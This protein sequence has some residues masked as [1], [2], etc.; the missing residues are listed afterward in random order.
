MKVALIDN[1]NN[2]FFALAR[3]FRDLGVEANLYLIPGRTHKH[4]D[5]QEDTWQD[6]TNADWIRNFPLPYHSSSYIRPIAGTIRRTFSKY[7]K[8]I[9]CGPSLGLFKKAGI[10]VDLFIPYGSDLF[11]L[12]FP[13][14]KSYLWFKSAIRFPLEEYRA[15]LQRSGIQCSRNIIVNTNWSAA[16]EALLKIECT[17]INLPRVMVYKEPCPTSMHD[18]Y[19][20]LSDYDFTV[21]SPTRHLWAT[22]ADPMPDF[23][24]NGG[25][26]RNDKL[27]RA[28]AKL[29]EHKLF[30]RPLLLL[31]DYGADVSHSKKLIAS[32]R[33]DE[34]V[35]WLPLLPRKEISVIM[36]HVSVVADQFRERMSATSAGTTNEAL[37][38]GKPIITNT[39]GAMSDVLD[40]YYSSP[41]LQALMENEIY[42]W[43]QKLSVSPDL[44]KS[45]GDTGAKWFDENL[46]LGLAQKYINLMREDEL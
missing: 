43:F 23:S 39:D 41:I 18:R 2:N 30:R 21:F 20:W 26:K 11:N 10:N 25:V 17:A 8:I 13:N 15:K 27:I 6:L 34:F 3:Y 37:A 4:F 44:V 28:F 42:E 24:Q 31:C 14:H 38:A 7:D 33:I 22:N 35:K 29:V 12:P 46:G 9:A 19:A 36:H 16:N 45:I 5:P 40:P 32:C 1:M